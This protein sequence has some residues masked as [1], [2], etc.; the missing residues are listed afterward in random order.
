MKFPCMFLASKSTVENLKN[1][2]KNAGEF[3]LMNVLLS[4]L[5]RNKR[6]AK[7]VGMQD[8]PNISMS[9]GIQ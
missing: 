3:A 9:Y 8:A 1:P 7:H 2:Q 4:E 6:G 5:W